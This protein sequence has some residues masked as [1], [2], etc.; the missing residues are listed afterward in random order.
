MTK[1]KKIDSSIYKMESNTKGEFYDINIISKSC[2]CP[3]YRFRMA[4]QEGECKHIIAVKE[5][6]IEKSSVSQYKSNYGR[7][8][9][10]TKKKTQKKRHDITLDILKEVEDATNINSIELIEKY[11]ELIINDLIEKGYLIEQNNKIKL[12]R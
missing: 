10:T 5:Y 6:I 8:E 11:G 3:H 12:M 4:K 1:I 9:K 7:K 2:T